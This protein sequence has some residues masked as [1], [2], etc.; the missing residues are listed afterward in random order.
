MSASVSRPWR[1]LRLVT[2]LNIGGPAIH[3]I[4]LTAR[5]NSGDFR[6]R[7]VTGQEAPTEGN[8]LG[9][10][11]ANGVRPIVVS[12]I[13]REVSPL[14]DTAA[15]LKLMR[16]IGRL[17]PDVVHTHTAKAGT[18]G[19]IAAAALRVP[20]IV[21]TYHGHV[22]HSYF[23]RWQT[24]AF[25]QIE[26]ALARV[27]QAIVTVGEKQREEIL[28]YGIG[29]PD[30]VH[31]I[32]LGLE[33]ERFI[34]CERRRGELRQEL[35]IL[36]E[37]PLI[38]IVARLVPVKAHEDFLRAAAHVCRTRPDAAF[39]IVGD[40]ER[41]AELEALTGELGL[42]ENVRFLGWRSDL[43][44]IYADLDV[45]ALSSLNEGSPVALIE[46]LAAGRP[47]AATDVGG[48]REVVVSGETG[49]LTPAREPEALARSICSLL[50]D[51][52]LAGRLGE[53]G[54]RHV[55]PHHT[56]GRLSADLA[57]LYRSM[58][59]ARRRERTGA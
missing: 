12:E 33:L 44:R 43:E 51:R 29:T 48:V 52:E 22:F 39:L 1:I 53:C 59:S 20:V 25:L 5:L 18:L 34:G 16:I 3:T 4:L 15:E 9:L 31:A 40:G 10:A 45:V 24:R 14:D 26:R 46:A 57:G 23:S 55:Y 27:T 49:L 11:A 21:H 7:L 13:G 8:L 19:R 41:R 56:I 50:E 17:R 32:P 54:R 2:R 6:S 42:N 30:K 36:P 35:G 28:S 38:G 47:V 37:Q 58:L